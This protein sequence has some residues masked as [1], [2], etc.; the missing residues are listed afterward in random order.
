MAKKELKKEKGSEIGATFPTVKRLY[1]TFAGD[2]VT[3][4]IIYE[5]VKKFGVVPNIRG[6]SMTES[7]GI[8]SLELSGTDR[9]IERA[10]IWL[11]KQGVKVDP[12]ELNVIEP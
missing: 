5:L 10:T 7:M 11:R 6:A 12:I 8:L 9:E 4:P 1:L 2:V 3:R